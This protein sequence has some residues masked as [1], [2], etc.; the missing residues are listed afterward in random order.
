MSEDAAQLRE[1]LATYQVQLQQVEA[2]L[3]NEPDSEEL[4][5][6]KT[7]LEEVV[8]LTEDLVKIAPEP[9]ARSQD[10]LAKS[11]VQYNWK[12][13]DKCQALWKNSK[14]YSARI[15]G[16]SDDRSTCKVIFDGY[17]SLETVRYIDVKPAGVGDIYTSAGHDRKK[18]PNDIARAKTTKQHKKELQELRKKKVQ[19]KVTR[20][21]EIEDAREKEK[22]RWKEFAHRSGKKGAPIGGKQ[23]RSIF[24]VPDSIHGKVG[25][26]TCNV[27]GKGMTGYVQ[28]KGYTKSNS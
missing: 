9:S 14:Y 6:L 3:T 4:K 18:N 12:V 16:V 27:G 17:D 24:A 28:P 10:S 8:K 1:S 25:V 13:G 15:L 26:G 2:A 21:Q 22:L 23:K 11:D 7:D 5:K 19:K 20:L